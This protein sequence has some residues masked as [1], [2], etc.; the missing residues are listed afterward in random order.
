MTRNEE[1]LKVILDALGGDSSK[2]PP[3]TISTEDDLNYLAAAFKDSVRGPAIIEVDG[4]GKLSKTF[5]EIAASGFSVLASESSG[6]T[7]YT[8][9]TSITPASFTVVYGEDTYVATAADK[10]PVLD[11]D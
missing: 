9:M 8:G 10:Q 5:A 2:V 6:T 11:E 1:Y 4:N 7:T 3:Y